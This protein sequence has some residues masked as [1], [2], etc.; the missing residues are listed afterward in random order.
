[1]DMLIQGARLENEEKKVRQFHSQ[2]AEL[3]KLMAHFMAKVRAGENKQQ[4]LFV[5]SEVYAA[6]S[7]FFFLEEQNMQA[8]I[9]RDNYRERCRMIAHKKQHAEIL[10]DIGRAI[11]SAPRSDEDPE[12]SDASSRSWLSHAIDA[13]VTHLMLE[14]RQSRRSLAA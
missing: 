8:A 14:S 1:M 5:L 13:L 2:H 10:N 3:V 11:A 7:E 12:T 4:L 6:A 9:D